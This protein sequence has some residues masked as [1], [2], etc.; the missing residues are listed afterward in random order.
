M[1]NFK[2]KINLKAKSLG[3]DLY[4]AIREVKLIRNKENFIKYEFTIYTL[5]S[6]LC[7]LQCGGSLDGMGA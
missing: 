1:W 7:R 5:R 4:L 3:E 2:L 6:L